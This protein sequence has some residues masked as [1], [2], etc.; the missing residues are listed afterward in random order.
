MGRYLMAGRGLV[1]GAWFARVWWSW[2][3]SGVMAASPP[4]RV[5]VS[6]AAVLLLS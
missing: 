6:H 4:M 5:R 3:T 1:V 2:K